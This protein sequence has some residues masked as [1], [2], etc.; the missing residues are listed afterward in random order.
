MIH[1]NTEP[2][3]IYDSILLD[4]IIGDNDEE[5]SAVLNPEDRDP[6]YFACVSRTS[7]KENEESISVKAIT[8]ILRTDSSPIAIITP[9]IIQFILRIKSL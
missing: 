9:K 7:F 4:V 3:P 2:F 8:V 6:E 1:R 5:I